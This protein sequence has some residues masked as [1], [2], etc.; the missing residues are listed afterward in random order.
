MM[1]AI[2]A[3]RSGKKVILLEKNEKLGKK[4]YIT[5]K[6]R[7]NITNCCHMEEL[8]NNIVT[9][10]RFMY[11]PLYGFTNDDV[12][13]LLEDL[14]CPVKVERGNRVFPQ[15]DKASDV[16]F[17]LR[18]EIERLGV[19]IRY[20]AQVR[21]I[22]YRGRHFH[23][24]ELAD[25]SS[26]SADACI[27]AT[28]GLSYPSTGS[29][30]EGYRFAREAG[31]RVTPLFPSLVPLQIRET[32]ECRELQGLSLRNVLC[33]ITSNGRELFSQRGEMLFTHFGVSG[34]VILSASA[35]LQP[36]LKEKLQVHVNLKPALSIEQL[37]QRILRDFEKNKNKEFKNSLDE[38]LP[39]KL[40]PVIV[41]RSGILP[42]KKV[43][44]ISRK[45][46]TQLLAEITDYTL[47]VQGLRGY[48]EAIITRG[49][50][51]VDEINPATMESRLV[52][53]LYFAGEIL[54]LDA[55]TGG[56]NLQIAWSTGYWAGLHAGEASTKK[57]TKIKY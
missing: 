27:V 39:R 44:S 51:S 42:E 30:G 55:L 14:G 43:N 33:T 18:R 47:T 34:P 37:D 32:E 11:S 6:G 12:M 23:S 9:N 26:A 15:S 5:G 1:A 20:H 38:L 40:I 29:T 25:G 53:G 35:F 46:R 3:A 21:R 36:H 13:G 16:I 22:I 28:G 4:V 50:V 41:K 57:N 54:D 10:P 7:C 56:F 17:A 49:G 45:E 48:Q 2:A 19:E 8:L 31:H 52:S 24:V